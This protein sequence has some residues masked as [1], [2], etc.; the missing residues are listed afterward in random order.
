MSTYVSIKYQLH[1]LHNIQSCLKYWK[2]RCVFEKTMIHQEKP[3][4]YIALYSGI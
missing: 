1:I 4:G 2:P 3:L